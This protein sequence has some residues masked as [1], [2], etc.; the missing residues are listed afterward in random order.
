MLPEIL[1]RIERAEVLDRLAAPLDGVARPLLRRA[2]VS[3]LLS[4]AWLGHRVHP[5][6][7]D[8]VIGTWMSANVLD[9]AGGPGERAAARRLVGLGILSS[10]PTAAAGLHD[11]LDYGSKVRRSGVV[12]AA[13][14]TVGL[15]LQTASWLARRKG[16]HGTGAWLSFAAIGVTGAGGYVGGHLTYV[17]GAGVE[18]TAFQE[19]PEG[20]TATVALA[21]LGDDAPRSVAVDGTPVLLVRSGDEVHALADTCNHAGCSL[22]EGVVADGAVRCACHGSRF[23]LLDGATLAGPAA[24]S[25]PVYRT[26]VRDGIVE[27][28]ER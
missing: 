9:L 12:H 15:A 25:Q 14:N 27:V 22:A 24:A 7:T 17:L 6:L 19:A 23:R 8:A 28:T 20:W 26:R 2:P 18:R 4:G 13:A 11:W 10:L 3:R 16:R 21:D 5:M 1:H